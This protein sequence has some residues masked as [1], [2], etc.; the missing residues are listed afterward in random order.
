MRRIHSSQ[1]VSTSGCARH[2]REL[3]K[4]AVCVANVE[5][6]VTENGIE[7]G[8]LLSNKGYGYGRDSERNECPK[9]SL[10]KEVRKSEANCSTRQEEQAHRIGVLSSRRG[11]ADKAVRGTYH[12][13]EMWTRHEK[14]Q[15]RDHPCRT[16]S[17]GGKHKSQ[18]VK[19]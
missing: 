7:K 10:A 18:T 9:P 11:S 1:N 14:G 6:S 3:Q 8:A 2:R 19:V 4:R 17:L 16:P 13:T 5:F 15:I 12:T